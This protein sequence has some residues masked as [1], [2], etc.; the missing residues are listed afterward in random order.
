MPGNTWF[1]ETERLKHKHLF[2]FSFV[3]TPTTHKTPD[4]KKVDVLWV[5]KRF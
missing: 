3:I 5:S 2:P 4:P 1:A